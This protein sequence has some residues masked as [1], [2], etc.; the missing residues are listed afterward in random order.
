MWWQNLTVCDVVSLLSVTLLWHCL[1]TSWKSKH[2]TR[3]W[4]SHWLI[5]MFF[6][7]A[8]YRN[9][10]ITSLEET[11]ILRWVLRTHLLQRSN[12][13][14]NHFC[15]YHPYNLCKR[16]KDINEKFLGL[17]ISR[18]LN[19]GPQRIRFFCLTSQML[20]HDEIFIT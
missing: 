5:C 1:N 20:N 6:Y 13:S 18:G 7:K 11:L 16:M 3:T 15:S 9:I 10:Q 14:L 19:A 17:Y 12:R 4:M 8:F 2:K